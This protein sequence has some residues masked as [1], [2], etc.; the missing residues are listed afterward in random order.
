M[1]CSPES[2]RIMLPSSSQE[3]SHTSGPFSALGP[4]CSM[5]T[6]GLR[7]SVSVFSLMALA[8][9]AGRMW[10]SHSL[11]GTT[12][13]C[14]ERSCY[15]APR[16][17]RTGS[18]SHL[19][20]APTAALLPPQDSAAHSTMGTRPQMLPS[21]EQKFSSGENAEASE[22]HICLMSRLVR[23][24]SLLFFF[25]LYKYLYNLLSKINSLFLSQ[26]PNLFLIL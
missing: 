4:T 3:C 25:F 9:A 26:T 13:C 24:T 7:C 11:A 23:G 1:T 22:K 18:C 21:T 17:Q 12:G 16:S 15:V 10:D 5:V 6:M 2:S 8:S 20:P 19:S 14:S